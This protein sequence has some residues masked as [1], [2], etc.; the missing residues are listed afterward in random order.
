MAPGTVKAGAQVRGDGVD[1]LVAVALRGL[2]PQDGLRPQVQSADPLIGVV[3][4]LQLELQL[5]GVVHMAE[6][7]AAAS[8]PDR[9]VRGNAE[10]GGKEQFLSL[11]VNGAGAHLYNPDPPALSRNGPGDKNRPAP[12]PRHPGAVVGPPLNLTVT[13]LVFL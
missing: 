4:P 6:G 2:R 10:R 9:A 3:D 12:D 1:R 11:P 7:A 5:P 13:E 8:G